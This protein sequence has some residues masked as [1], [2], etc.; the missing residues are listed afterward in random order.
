M[1]NQV[2]LIS[3]EEMKN[4]MNHYATSKIARNAPGVVFAAK[5][6]DTAITAYKSGKV[7][8]QGAGA[9]RE[10]ARWGPRRYKKINNIDFQRG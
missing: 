3:N 2:I 9:E 6:P 5:T 10:A 7:L 1:G 4:V 8:F